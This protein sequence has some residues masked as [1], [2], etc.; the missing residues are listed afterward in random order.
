[1]SS[2]G[3][4]QKMIASNS[5]EDIH[6]SK[7]CRTLPSLATICLHKSTDAKFSPLTAAEKDVFEKV[8]EDVVGGPSIVLT[9]K[10]VVVETFI[11]KST[12]ICKPFH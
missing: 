11:R 4:V 3:A 1:M 7:L 2:L 12:N 9:H 5:D 6:K 8:R 10:T